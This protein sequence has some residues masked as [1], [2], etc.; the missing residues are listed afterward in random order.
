VVLTTTHSYQ[1][2]G[3][4][5][6][7]S[8]SRGVIFVTDTYKRTVNGIAVFSEFYINDVLMHKYDTILVLEAVTQDFFQIKTSSNNPIVFDT[9][10]VNAH[11]SG[12]DKLVRKLNQ[13]RALVE[14]NGYV[15]ENS[16]KKII[17]SHGWVAVKFRL[18]FYPIY[19]TLKN[20][21]RVGQLQRLKYYDEVCFISGS[22][23]A[24]RHS[25]FT[26]V[27]ANKLKYEL[28]DF[29]KAYLVRHQADVK[30]PLGN[31]GNGFVFTIANFEPVKN[32]W[33]LVRYAIQRKVTGSKPKN[34]I[35]LTQQ[36]TSINYLLFAFLANKLNI[37]ICNDQHKKNELLSTCDYFFIPSYSEYTPLV[38]L[39]AFKYNKQVV[40]LY[41][42]TALSPLPKYH[43][44]KQ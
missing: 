32:I 2:I 17:I 18:Q 22:S 16:F 25:D 34:I 31:Q 35:L 4:K 12:A 26:Y 1:T 33:W 42:I 19:Y 39:E 3:L 29:I 24:Y 7:L 30:Q 14:A 41:K 15:L 5:F 36:K 28:Y 27:K 40:S 43:Y 21:I 20:I 9:V 13:F 37:A 38:A 6:K 23:D 8:V 10:I 11:F 44:L